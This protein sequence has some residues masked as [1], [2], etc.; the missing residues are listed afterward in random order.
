[1]FIIDVLHNYVFL[2]YF[3]GGSRGPSFF[4]QPEKKPTQPPKQLFS[5]AY[6]KEKALIATPTALPTGR[7][8]AC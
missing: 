4:A 3:V 8:P 1:M 2:T 5:K 6:P 7:L